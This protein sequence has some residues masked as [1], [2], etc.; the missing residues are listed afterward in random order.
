MSLTADPAAG[1]DPVREGKAYQDLLLGLVGADDP[2]EI[3]AATPAAI[4]AHA[5][6]RGG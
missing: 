5:A 4:R 3:Q 2:A 1:P 6:V